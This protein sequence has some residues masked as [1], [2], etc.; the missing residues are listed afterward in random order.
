MNLQARRIFR[1]ALTTAL[2]LVLAYAL[3]LT[4]AFMAPLFAFILTLH[5]AP[6]MGAKRLLALVILVAVTTGVGLLLVPLL[7]YFA[8]AAVLVVLLGLYLSF[9]LTV[10]K[11]QP[12]LGTLVAIGFT[13]ISATSL[14]DFTLGKMLV[15]S[16]L[17]G[18]VIAI[19]CQ[20]LVYPLFPEDPQAAG[21]E[22]QEAPLVDAV[23]SRWIAIRGTLI[24]LPVYLLAL[25]NPSLFV[26]AIMKSVTLGQQ[27]SHIDIAHAGRQ[28]LGSTFLAAC[29][30]MAAWMGLRILPNLWMY[31]LLML[32]TAI[33][34]ASKI[35]GALPTRYPASFWSNV[36]TT[37][38]ILLGPAVAG[39]SSSKDVYMASFVRLSLFVF[40]SFY[41]WWTVTLLDAWR[42]HRQSR[43]G[44]ITLKNT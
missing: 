25:N 39:I 35:Y 10:Y 29:L 31:F 21:Q 15:E 23:A 7:M 17:S 44:A 16:F 37:Q 42:H 12:A 22:V 14:Y 1:L 20:W 3:N 4:F 24:V 6:P 8:P 9:Y 43:K 2:T 13:V 38:L 30:A 11:Q 33:F 19:V 32:L 28:L 26:A 40:I 41:A 18:I 5:P 27:T 36:M 34:V